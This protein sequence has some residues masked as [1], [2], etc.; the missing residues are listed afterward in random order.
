MSE[1][2]SVRYLTYIGRELKLSA[3]FFYNDQLTGTDV[4]DLLLLIH[5]L[6]H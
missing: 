2:V 1:R 3:A 5:F 6:K 4:T